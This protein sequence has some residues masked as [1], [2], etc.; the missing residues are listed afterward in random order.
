MAV[1]THDQ[2]PVVVTAFGIVIPSLD[3][4]DGRIHRS[5]DIGGE[6]ASLEAV[7]GVGPL[8]PLRAVCSFVMNRAGGV[9]TPEPSGTGVMVVTVA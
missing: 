6:T 7:Q 5:D 8:A 4:G 1:F 9:V 2:G 3:K